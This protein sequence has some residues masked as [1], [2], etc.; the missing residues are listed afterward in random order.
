VK[1]CSCLLKM[2]LLRKRG[3]ELKLKRYENNKV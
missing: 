1:N 2:W 3:R